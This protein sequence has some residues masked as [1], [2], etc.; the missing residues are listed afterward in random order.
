MI[1]GKQKFLETNY[2][3][4]IEN[5]PE[6]QLWTFQEFTSAMLL[7]GSRTFCV[8]VN[9]TVTNVMVPFSD[10]LNHKRPPDAIWAYDNDL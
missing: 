1:K 5:I 3:Y 2:N 8:D 6:I 7:V 10:M 4:L 9:G